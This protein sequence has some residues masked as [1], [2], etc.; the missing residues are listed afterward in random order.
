MV[1]KELFQKYEVALLACTDLGRMQVEALVKSLDGLT[2]QQ[3]AAK[4][5]LEYPRLLQSYG[6][7]AAQATVQWY[8][9]AR[10]AHF[11]D[12]EGAERYEAQAA[13]PIRD[14]W[15]YEDLQKA[16]KTGMAHLPGMAVNRI[17]QRADRTMAYNVA[18]DPAHPCWAI[19]PNFGACGFCV[20][21]GSNGFY[22][23]RQPVKVQRHSHCRCTVVVDWDTDNP[24][25]DGY[26]PDALYRAYQEAE[27]STRAYV[28]YRWSRMSDEEKEQYRRKGRSAKDVFKTKVISKEIKRRDPSWVQDGKPVRVDYS[29]KPRTAYG[30]LKEDAMDYRKES[31]VTRGNE[32]KDLF[33]HDALSRSGFFTCLHETINNGGHTN[34]DADVQS[35]RCEFKSPEATPNPD[36]K[37]ELRFVQKNVQ[38]ARH[39]FMD[40]GTAGS[41][42]RMVMNNYYTGFNDEDEMRVFEKFCSELDYQ[43]FSEGL[44]IKKDG[45][46]LRAK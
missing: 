27:E 32:W 19:V 36:S 13:A 5:M 17:M 1:D 46:V 29:E 11:E 34:I 35:R 30:V 45:T 10:D 15:A 16:A 38:A 22:M 21:I 8:Q 18:R 23:K 2:P 42:M 14:S 40:D 39:Q 6:Q 26:N 24:K 31:F 4:L 41:G 7:A 25:L 12:D 3:Q 33:V 9:E 28:D 43:G 20:M 37:D 44:F